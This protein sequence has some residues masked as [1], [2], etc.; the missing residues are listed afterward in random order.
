MASGGAVSWMRRKK[1]AAERRAQRQR[2]QARV[3]GAVVKGVA[4][5]FAHRGGQP[6][7]ALQVLAAAL[8]GGKVGGGSHAHD[9]GDD[10]APCGSRTHAG[11]D[12]DYGG[13]DPWWQGG[14]DPWG[15]RAAAAEPVAKRAKVGAKS[16]GQN[17]VKTVEKLCPWFH[18]LVPE[19]P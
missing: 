8:S 5:L 14:G 6:T 16:M 15:G 10:G 17:I 7:S 4:E 11:G 3:I 18:A 9:R 1:T 2:A 19:L 12:D 13:G